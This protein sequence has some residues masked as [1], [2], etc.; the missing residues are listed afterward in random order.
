MDDQELCYTDIATL[1][2]RYR[3]RALSP[4]E[5]T[6]AVL[7]RIG[8]LDRRLNSFITVLEQ[9]ALEQARQAEAE[10]F[11][12][13]DR[14]P[15]HGVPV[16]LK[17]LIDTAGIRTTAASRLW[18]DR[19][20]AT[21]ATVA[22]RLEQAGAVL[23]GKCNLLEFAYGIVHPDYGQC[24]NPWDVARTSGGSSSG[25]AASVAAG[26]GWGSIGTDTGG[27]IRIPA[28][29]CGV[30]GLKPTYGRV[31]LYGVCPLSASLD[32]AG[33]LARTVADAAIL[34]GAIAG[35]DPLD[36]SSLADPPAD[37]HAA[38]ADSVRGLRVGVVVE[39]IGDDLHPG[40]ADATWAAVR[41]L[42]QAGMQLREVHIARLREADAPLLAV[43]MP[44][45]TLVHAAWLR[46]RPADYAALTRAQLEQ[47]ARITAVDYLQAR[48]F[49]DQLRAD[50]LEALRDVDVLIGPA[51]A[52]EAPA[53]DP[54]VGDSEG[55][56][57]ARR[58][59]PYNMTGLPA[60]SVPC[61]FGRQGL[62]LGLQIAAAPLAEQMLL[63]VAHAYEQ[64]AGWFQQRPPLI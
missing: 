32:H 46:E 62:P 31:S 6:R 58:T 18:R 51:V 42:E 57:E 37:Y 63:R 40:V 16:S 1:G 36:P 34:L 48:A 11:Q 19:V 30:V 28:A 33:P 3:S 7:D 29:Y 49:C 24:N 44:E 14:G 56:A 5:A 61:G 35:H 39:H 60:I 9:P 17:D 2:W 41:E 50:L 27:S 43:V 8:R 59:A 47:G 15:L 64:R 38:L 10:L 26:M 22:S 23:I 25:S 54:P 20:P 52:W 12:G 21:T 4:V 55:A 13:I 45:A 53:E